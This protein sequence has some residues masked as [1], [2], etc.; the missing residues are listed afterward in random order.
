[1]RTAKLVLIVAALYVTLASVAAAAVIN[2]GTA[3]NISGP[4]DVNL[5]G[6]TLD[7]AYSFGAGT[8]SINGVTFNDFTTQ[9]SD[10]F[11][12]FTGNPSPFGGYGNN[13][14]SGDYGTLLSN[15][16]WQDGAP[17]SITFNNL[18]A[19]DN[20][21]IG[22]WVNDSRGCCTDRSMT[23]SGDTGGVTGTLLYGGPSNTDD[24]NPNG[25]FVYGTFKA[26]V[27]GSQT[28]NLD[29]VGLNSNNSQINGVLLTYSVSTPE[30]ASLVLAGLGAVGLLLA[31]RRRRARGL[32]TLAA[33][34]ALLACFALAGDAS[35]ANI[36]WDAPVAI[37]TNGSASDVVNLGTTVEAQYATSGLGAQ[38]VNG[39]TF[40][41][42]F[43]NYAT[44]NGT[45]TGALS[46][47]TGNGAY[48][49]ILNGFA[50]DGLN[51]NTLTLTGLTVGKTYDVQI[52]GLDDR[53]CCSSRTESFT[54]GSNTS[55]TF[56]V[57]SNVS[58]TGHFVADATTQAVLLNGVDQSQMNLNAFAV[59]TSNT[60]E[61]AALVLAGLG[62]VGLLVAAR[63]RNG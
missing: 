36:T 9:N 40:Q 7:R 54:G 19:G 52:W 49:T 29:L 15:G 51:P 42:G 50:Y 22:V 62:A 56:A 47:S 44:P 11:T 37:T 63:R 48:D 53:D 31:A 5:N 23:L 14:Q 1:M 32:T 58:I 24:T 35:A 30:P 3:Q 60:P 8:L 26:D 41:E 57:G 55:A 20:Y 43:T 25:Q 45:T 4:T 16:I 6:Q 2:F 34:V 13:G 33:G 12:G 39:V 10:T 28:L 46:G 61:P 38:T 17:S 27:T 59:T 21:T 18:Q